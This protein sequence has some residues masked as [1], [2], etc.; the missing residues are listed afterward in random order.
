MAGGGV[1]RTAQVCYRLVPPVC[2]VQEYVV[3][4]V[5]VCDVFDKVGAPVYVVDA[6]EVRSCGAVEAERAFCWLVDG[7]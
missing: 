5:L 3:A 4:S 1:E 2:F 7:V 6:L